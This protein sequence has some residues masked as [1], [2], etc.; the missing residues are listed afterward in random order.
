MINEIE[1][2]I[3]AGTRDGQ[4]VKKMSQKTFGPFRILERTTFAPAS[5][6]YV[7]KCRDR[8][9]SIVYMVF[10]SSVDDYFGGF[11]C[12]CQTESRVAAFA[13]LDESLGR[14]IGIGK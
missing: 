5:P 2:E 10:D 6:V 4:G 1:S 7:D 3:E 14:T 11:Y 12:F 8:F 13:G 9:G